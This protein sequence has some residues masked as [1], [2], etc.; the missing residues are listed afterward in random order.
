MD[1]WLFPVLMIPAGAMLLTALSPRLIKAMAD[2]HEAVHGGCSACTA[3]ESGFRLRIQLLAGA[4]CL[5]VCSCFV[6][7]LSGLL[8]GA[9]QLVESIPPS[10]ALG[11]LLVGVSLLLAGCGCF[12]AE[13]ILLLR[14][15]SRSST[16]RAV[17]HNQHDT[18]GVPAPASARSTIISGD[19]KGPNTGP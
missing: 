19:L 4:T 11:L 2:L 10:V 16:P 6:F 1:N 17:T 7:A 14:A 13:G 3:H 18:P 12:A 15:V 5:L 9:H 8:G